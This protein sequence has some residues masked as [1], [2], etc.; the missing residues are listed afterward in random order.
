MDI[1][2]ELH[3]A[4]ARAR[5]EYKWIESEKAGFDLGHNAELEWDRMYLPDFRRHYL[6]IMFDAIQA[7]QDINRVK[8]IAAD[9]RILMTEFCGR[10]W[11]EKTYA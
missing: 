2:A 4:E 6:G 9:L 1:F 7:E 5:A 11:Q 10:P 3:A 8:Y